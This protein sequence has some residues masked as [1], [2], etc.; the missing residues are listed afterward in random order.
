[1]KACRR[2]TE[3]R[4]ILFRNKVQMDSDRVLKHQLTFY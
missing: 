4:S 3:N 1:M 2:E